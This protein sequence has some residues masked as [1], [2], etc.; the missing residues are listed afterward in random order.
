M[1]SFT[2]PL[3]GEKQAEFD[4]RR[5]EMIHFVQGRHAWPRSRTVEFL[6]S[7]NHVGIAYIGVDMK[8][9]TRNERQRAHEYD[10][11]ADAYRG[12]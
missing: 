9:A 11:Y 10:P 2:Q 4:A 12:I 3:P 5:E 7:L 8:E 6:E 1:T